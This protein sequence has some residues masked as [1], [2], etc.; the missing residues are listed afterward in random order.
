MTRNAIYDQHE[1]AFSNVSAFVVVK[2]GERI[3]T[4]AFKFPKDGAGR[5]YCYLHV[6]GLP[7]VR[8]HA[9]GYGYDKKSAAF[10]DA[11][12]K[13]AKVKLGSWQTSDYSAEYAL[14]ES[15]YGCLNDSHDWHNDL[16]DAGFTVMQAI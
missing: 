15:L 14:A 9:G 4:V 5:L 12:E 13:Q 2:D 3:A 11:A 8:G 7:M 1:K 16:R 6:I 10:R